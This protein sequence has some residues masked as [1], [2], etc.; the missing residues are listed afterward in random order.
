MPKA[1]RERGIKPYFIFGVIAATI[2]MAIFL[3]LLY[4]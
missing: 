4:G 2:E 3:W 1:G